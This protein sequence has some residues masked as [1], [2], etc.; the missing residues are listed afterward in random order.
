MHKCKC[1]SRKHGKETKHEETDK[2]RLRQL[3]GFRIAAKTGRVIN[4][5]QYG[6]KT[7]TQNGS[8]RQL[9]GLVPF[10]FVP[11]IRYRYP[12]VPFFG[13]LLSV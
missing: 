7:E 3:R 6:N 10:T 2:A 8:V 13:T 11:E 9:I 4:A 1:K 5:E 12:T